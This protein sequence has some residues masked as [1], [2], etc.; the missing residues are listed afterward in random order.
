MK[1][2]KLNFWKKKN[3]IFERKNLIFERK[4]LD[5]WKTSLIFEKIIEFLALKVPM[6]FLNKFHPIWPC[7]LASYKL[8][9]TY[10][11]LLKK[12]FQESLKSTRQKNY[13]LYFV[14]YSTVIKVKTFRKYGW[15]RQNTGLPTKNEIRDDPTSSWIRW[16]KCS[17]ILAKGFEYSIY[18]S[19]YLSKSLPE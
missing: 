9:Q 10:I 19:N 16:K 3:L 5:F 15:L 6:G 1:E 12:G 13:F 17:H 14:Y 11:F 4:K 18:L 2:K 8:T 7:R